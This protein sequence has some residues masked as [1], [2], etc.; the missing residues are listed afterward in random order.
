MFSGIGILLLVVILV[1][2]IIAQ[3]LVTGAF[4]KYSRVR[5]RSGRT[6]AEA[7][8]EILADAGIRDV[9]VI[10]TQS[11]LGDHYDPKKK[12]LALSPDVY[13]SESVAALGIA[14]H[15]AGHAI[16][17]QHAYWPLQVRMAVVPATML[18][19]QLLP[20][21]MIGGFFLRIY[22][23]VLLGIAIYT[24][25]VVFQLITLPVEFNASGRAKQILESGGLV[26]RDEMVGVHRVLNA[27]AMTY[28]AALIAAIG[29]L[30]Q[31]VLLSRN[32]D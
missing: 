22:P 24:V 12:V 9:Q 8:Q 2:G 11:F 4:K 26:A 31:L 27:A 13:R 6:G 1:P 28:V 29:H 17:H 18:G 7:A 19:S 5:A 15:E 21:V 32:R 25:I 3:L 20:L 23:L 16:Q 30:L 14:A 10:E